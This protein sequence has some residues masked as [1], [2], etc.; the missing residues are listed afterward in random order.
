MIV[1]IDIKYEIVIKSASDIA[2][3]T[4]KN[5]GAVSKKIYGRLNPA[6]NS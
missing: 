3:G 2:E 6:P 4:D 5:F 1:G